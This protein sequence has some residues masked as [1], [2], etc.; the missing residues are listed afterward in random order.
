MTL[1]NSVDAQQSGFQSLNTTTGAWHGRTLQ[2]GTNI[3]ITN[4][5]GISGNP[6]ISATGGGAETINGDTGSITGSTLTIF[7]NQ[8]A[9]NS[10]ASVAFTNTGTTSTFNVTDGNSN[11]LIG[12][13]SGNSNLSTTGLQNTA[14]GGIT[15]SASQADQ[16]IVAIGYSS[17]TNF[18]GGNNNTH[19]GHSSASIVAT[20]SSNCSVGFMSMQGSAGADVS[21]TTCIG[22]FSGQTLATSTQNTVCGSISLGSATSASFNSGLGYNALGQ[23]VSG[24]YNTVIGYAAGSSYV[25]NETSNILIGNVGTPSESNVIRIGTDGTGPAQQNLCFLAGIISASPSGSPVPLM[26]DS[27]TGQLTPGSGGGGGVTIDGDTGSATGSTITF[28][29]TPTA[30]STTSFSASGSTVALN[31][32]DANANTIL[33]LN[34]G[35]S[36]ISGTNTTGFGSLALANFGG[37]NNVTAIGYQ[38]LNGLGGNDNCTAVGANAV[39]AM[40]GQGNTG[41]GSSSLGS[42]SGGSAGFNTCVGLNTASNLTSGSENLILG[43]AATTGSGTQYTSSES[44]NILLSNI[45]VTGESNTMRLG[46][47]GLITSTFV[48]GV[49]GVTVTGSAVLCDTNG[50]LGTIASS[51]RFKEDITTLTYSNV[52]NLTPVS[53][54]YKKPSNLST[55]ID[56]DDSIHYGMIAEDVAIHM[57]ELVIYD[58]GIPFTIKYHELYALL[59]L[60]I[61]NLKKEIE[62]LKRST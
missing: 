50:Q 2:Q 61:K 9:V 45:G 40:F 46:T 52:T 15:L 55:N 5:D 35:N 10:G 53:F 12:L 44:Q 22:A 6:V 38:A 16:G 60:E 21:D 14:L 58:Q 43:T 8:A 34:A 51:E 24:N 33:G 62:L 57:P 56:H 25:S 18:N 23:L 26:V 28:N 7:A 32:T 17:M 47:D 37:G 30:G 42:A 27:V 4:P 13:N 59:L 19:V 3:T 39:L 49:T 11:T 48:A 29:A 20:G 41:I 1:N 36:G 31:V 54:K